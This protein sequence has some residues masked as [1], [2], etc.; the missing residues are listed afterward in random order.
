MS[1]LPAIGPLASALGVGVTCSPGLNSRGVVVT[2]KTSLN[3][4]WASVVSGQKTTT[5]N[6]VQNITSSVSS[7]LLNHSSFSSNNDDTFNT[8]LAAPSYDKQSSVCTSNRQKNIPSSSID[9]TSTKSQLADSHSYN[10]FSTAATSLKLS[11]LSN[12]TKNLAT[13]RKTQFPSQ[14]SAN[15]SWAKQSDRFS[16]CLNTLSHD[17]DL[18]SIDYKD[19]NKNQAKLTDSHVSSTNTTSSITPPVSRTMLQNQSPTPMSTS[20][21]SSANITEPFYKKAESSDAFPAPEAILTSQFQKRWADEVSDKDD[22][23]ELEKATELQQMRSQTNGGQ[24]T[25]KRCTERTKQVP[26]ANSN[27]TYLIRH[28]IHTKSHSRDLLYHDSRNFY[29]H[30]NVSSQHYQKPHGVHYGYR[31]DYFMKRQSLSLQNTNDDIIRQ[32][33]PE[34]RLWSSGME[35]TNNKIQSYTRRH[36]RSQIDTLN[37]NQAMSWDRETLSKNSLGPKKTFGANSSISYSKYNENAQ[38]KPSHEKIQSRCTLDVNE[39]NAR[40]RQVNLKSTSSSVHDDPITLKTNVQTKEG[41]PNT[42][43]WSSSDSVKTQNLELNVPPKTEKNVVTTDR[44]Y[45]ILKDRNQ[46]IPHDN[47]RNNGRTAVKEENYH[48]F[49]EGMTEAFPSQANQVSVLTTT[50]QNASKNKQSPLIC[51]NKTFNSSARSCRIQ[52]DSDA[53]DA[54]T[55]LNQVLPYQRLVYSD[56][57]KISLNMTPTFVSYKSYHPNASTT[58]HSESDPQSL[59]RQHAERSN[60]FHLNSSSSVENV[61]PVLNHSSKVHSCYVPVISNNVLSVNSSVEPHRLPLLQK[62]HLPETASHSTHSSLVQK[63]FDSLPTYHETMPATQPFLRKHCESFVV[64]ENNT[65]NFHKKT[66]NKQDCGQC[67]NGTIS[68]YEAS[69]CGHLSDSNNY[70]TAVAGRNNLMVMMTPAATRSVNNE[71][72]APYN[73]SYSSPSSMHTSGV[74]G[75]YFYFSQGPR[76]QPLDMYSSNI[77]RPLTVCGPSSSPTQTIH[78]TNNSSIKTSSDQHMSHLIQTGYFH[79]IPVYDAPSS[80]DHCSTKENQIGNKNNKT[81]VTSASHAEFIHCYKPC[82]NQ[83]P[84]S[85][86]SF[87]NSTHQIPSYTQHDSRRYPISVS[88]NNSHVS[89]TSTDA[90]PHDLSSQSVLP[91]HYYSQSV[92]T[93]KSSNTSQAKNYKSNK[94]FIITSLDKQQKSNCALSRYNTP[95]HI[96]QN[97]CTLPEI[98]DNV[99]DFSIPLIYSRTS[100]KPSVVRGH[101]AAHEQH[102]NDQ[103]TQN[104][105]DKSL[106]NK[107]D[108]PQN[109]CE[110]TL[111]NEETNI[112]KNQLKG[113]ASPIHTQLN[114]HGK[115]SYVKESQNN[116]PE[117]FQSHSNKVPSIEKRK[118]TNTNNVLLNLE[119]Q[120]TTVKHKR[121][122]KHNLNYRKNHSQLIKQTDVTSDTKELLSVVQH[123]NFNEGQSQILKSALHHVTK[124]ANKTDPQSNHLV[125]TDV[126]IESASDKDKHTV[127]GQNVAQ[128]KGKEEVRKNDQS[129]VENIKQPHNKHNLRQ[130]RRDACRHFLQGRCNFINCNF[131]HSN[132]INQCEM[133]KKKNS[134]EY[135]QKNNKTNLNKRFKDEEIP[136]SNFENESQDNSKIT[137]QEKNKN[138]ITNAVRISSENKALTSSSTLTKDSKIK[139]SGQE[140]ENS[141][142]KNNPTSQEKIINNNHL[143]NRFLKLSSKENQDESQSNPKQ[144]KFK[145]GGWYKS[146]R[147]NNNFKNYTKTSLKESGN[148][149]SN[150]EHKPKDSHSQKDFEPKK[151]VFFKNKKTGFNATERSNCSNACQKNESSH[152]SDISKKA[153]ITT[154]V[155]QTDN[156]KNISNKDE[157]KTQKRHLMSSLAKKI[158]TDTLKA[159]DAKP[160]NH[161]PLNSATR[162]T[163]TTD[164][165]NTGDHISSCVTTEELLTNFKKPKNRRNGGNAR[166]QKQNASFANNITVTSNNEV[167]SILQSHFHDEM[168]DTT[169]RSDVPLSK[170]M[171]KQSRKKEKT[172]GNGTRDTQSSKTKKKI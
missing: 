72:V 165:T 150:F 133:E 100:T 28:S 32:P 167:K 161:I 114:N 168:I 110:I 123:N 169:V 19:F 60:S 49:S 59:N 135:N 147:Q 140:N 151:N 136:N 68:P 70:S 82:T 25:A 149:E 152:N 172:E 159:T 67:C 7:T 50:L 141:P 131:L 102:E 122:S 160:D 87:Y 75:S 80:I 24:E 121:S 166:H 154:I 104:Y 38:K 119:T 17:V 23:D 90:L 171:K 65:Q 139:N 118:D 45:N 97:S 4:P 91:K 158:I 55:Q 117:L 3:Q 52:Q 86:V 142:T 107:L 22:D 81:I 14:S 153:Q 137:F 33:H 2:T 116:N 37:S 162:T 69:H 105:F 15:E 112:C 170:T 106:S 1:P 101:N 145:K 58:W 111:L 148:H 34:K 71:K 129:N 132:Q 48:C 103:F 88:T 125:K 36:S 51:N 130:I 64:E 108:T 99:N 115:K 156:E 163:I 143:K 83:Q 157:D 62:L 146:H 8:S 73:P 84:T 138:E 144:T 29:D 61:V 74:Q 78:V 35:P 113:R 44:D 13:P 12:V 128:H 96:S 46:S 124:E 42:N 53:I 92:N 79:G 164:R 39:S 95:I 127:L 63:S 16:S 30:K 120:I 10:K 109:V 77:A 98:I 26:L 89:Q 57:A 155:A 27:D 11:N 6:S 85:N 40:C 94:N 93:R 47:L 41:R 76:L 31:N 9:A 21:T 20:V 66:L 18:S 54:S 134:K 56:P 43:V 5:L 126:V